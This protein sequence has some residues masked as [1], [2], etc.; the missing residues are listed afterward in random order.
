MKRFT[1]GITVRILYLS[2]TIGLEVAGSGT[3]TNLTRPEEHHPTN[4][5]AAAKWE[6]H[7]FSVHITVMLF[8][9]IMILIKMAFHHIPYLADYVPES[10]LLI[11]LG[12]IFGVIVR[13]GIKVGSFEA[14]VWQLTP[15]LFFTYLLP[16]IVLESS[17]SLYN[18]TF[19]EYL[20]VVL[21]FAVLGTIFNFLIIGFAMY[22]LQRAGAFGGSTDQFDLNSMLLFSSLIVAVDPVAVLAI[23]Q[24]IGVDLGLY[25]IV[26]GESLLNDAITVVLYDIMSAFVGKD[27]ITG[28]QIGVGIAS[29]FTVSFGGLLIGV[30]IGIV[31]C[32]I[33]RIKSHLNSFTLIL[34]AYFSYIMADMVGWS[35]II[36][37]IG[38][39]LVQAAY[40]F[41]NL[42]FKSVSLVRKLT[43]L[44][45]EVSESV[46]FLFLGIEVVTGD[47]AWHTGFILWSITL[48]LISRSI[49][50]FALTAVINRV[51]VDGT[52]ISWANQVILVYGGLRGAVAFALAILIVSNNLGPHGVYNRRVMITATLYIILFTVGL[53]GVTMKPLVKVLKI[54]MQAKHELSLFNVL[55]GSVLDETLAASEAISNLKGRNVVREF[56]MR[57]DEKYIRR[58]LQREPEAYDQKIM[59]MYSKISMKLHLAS[60]QPEKSEILL[61]DVPERLRDKHFTSYQSSVSL[62]SMGKKQFSEDS[63]T[64]LKQYKPR[65]SITGTVVFEGGQIKSDPNE[66]AE[67]AG[68]M[69]STRRASLLPGAKRQMDF[70]EVMHDVMRSRERA[71]SQQQRSSFYPKFRTQNR[72]HTNGEDNEAY[73]AET[74]DLSDIQEVTSYSQ[75]EL[76]EPNSASRRVAFWVE[77]ADGQA[78]PTPKHSESN[79]SR[80]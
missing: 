24:D 33:T 59:H 35:G 12:I 2:L 62:H 31:S 41:H 53:M 70:D 58:I 63:L 6:F 71:M 72:L 28:H 1:V 75:A 13:Y 3:T 79:I 38:C 40:A 8:L 56:F 32:L 14:T 36:S 5:I 54:R 61:Q 74:E 43:K 50:V 49:I 66:A 11:L 78:T 29:F 27:T 10:L 9:L 44:V 46:I 47:L 51:N 77:P 4:T 76:N 26:F 55:M 30:I 67:L 25:Y 19:S 42:G 20:G 22:W 7:E 64:S 15:T 60:L 23:F 48:C 37:M 39:G 16:P 17:Y 21:I 80:V 73:I 52:K 69:R 45:A 57:L 65:R 68:Y 18:R 34:L